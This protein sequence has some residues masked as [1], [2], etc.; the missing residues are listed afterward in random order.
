M[1][2]QA[3]AVVVWRVKFDVFRFG[4]STEILHPHMMHTAPLRSVV[5]EH[6]V[7]RV[8]GEAGMIAR[9]PIVLKVRCR[10]VTFIIDVQAPAEIR[11]HVTGKTEAS[12]GGAL[13][14]F[15]QTGPDRQRR[16]NAQR[17]ERKNL[18]AWHPRQ[19]R[20]K[21]GQASE[22]YDNRGEEH[23]NGCSRVHK[24]GQ[25]AYSPNRDYAVN[26]NRRF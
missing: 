17:E 14:L 12:R 6:R 1:A 18:S 3:L 13:E 10:Q 4:N 9:H 24:N 7:I 11:H 21:R 20:L 8:A 23:E 22:N 16:Q 5:P 2:V 19:L 26:H 15:V 25:F